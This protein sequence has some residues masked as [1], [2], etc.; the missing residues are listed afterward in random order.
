MN[1]RNFLKSAALGA[2]LLGLGGCT[3]VFEKKHPNILFIFADDQAFDTINALGYDE[4]ETPN[5]DR[6]VRNGVT[7]TH[8][9]NMGAW[10]GAVCVASRTMLNTGRFLWEARDLEP[11]LLSEQDQGHFWSQ[12]MKNAGYDTY[13]SGKWHV[14]GIDPNDIFDHVRD[15]RPGMP[16][17]HFDWENPNQH[18]LGYDRPVEGEE[19]EWSP[20]DE[21]MGGFWQGGTHWSE[22]LGN[23]AIDF[24]EKA[25]SSDDPFF[26]YLAFNAPHDPRQSPKEY[27]DKYPL[28]N[29]SVPENFQPLYP[30]KDDI[31]CGYGLRDERLAPFPRTEYAVKVNRR[32]YYA[33]I[34]HMDAQIGRILDALEA[35][36][37]ADD[38]FIFFTADH[39]LAVGH[40]G[41]IGKQNM[42]DHSVRV[43]LFVNGPDVP[44]E[45]QINTPVYL[46]DVM[47]S[48]LDLAGIEKADHMDFNSLMPIIN[49]EKEKN[50]DLIYGGY[51]E[52]QRMVTDGDFKLIYYPKID[53]TILYNLVDD[54]MEMNNLADDP[55]YANK[56][57]EMRQKLREMQ[58]ELSDPLVVS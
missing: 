20:Y 28:E 1:R 15:V 22:V 17:D 30:H 26:M 2:G 53:K 54:P 48:S 51:M 56:V 32:E 4:V 41:L 55:H 11:E 29:V 43:P 3:T 5:L 49:G 57:Q 44:K 19:D 25:E 16:K 46:Q 7:F 8:A 35:S 34:T 24:L 12:V 18:H 14:K 58:V 6:L 27:V 31:G 21:S 50:Y 23:H 47:A 13:M 10:H 37:K 52:L 45:K 38:T 40:H 36:G 42:Y 33:I 39:G 9:Y